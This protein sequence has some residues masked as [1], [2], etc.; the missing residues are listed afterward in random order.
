MDYEGAR[1]RPQSD[2]LPPRY[3]GIQLHDPTGR[4]PPRPIQPLSEPQPPWDQ[5]PTGRQPV[6]PYQPLSA[7]LPPRD[8]HPTG[9]QP[10]RPYQNYVCQ[11]QLVK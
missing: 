5:H 3:E 7:R 4:Q 8:Q 1:P 11:H 9:R 10:Q 2:H 6:R